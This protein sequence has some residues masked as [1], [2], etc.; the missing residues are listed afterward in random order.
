VKKLGVFLR[1]VNLAGRRL[2][3]ADFKR[4]LA[5]AGYAEAQTVAAA[6]NAVISAKAADGKLEAAIEAAPKQRG[7]AR[8]WNTVNKMAELAGAP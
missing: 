5:A 4:A 6:G 1:A 3:M 7:A 2:A 8:N